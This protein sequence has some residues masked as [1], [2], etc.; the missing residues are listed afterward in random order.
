MNI[1]DP[2]ESNDLCLIN[3]NLTLLD[4]LPTIARG[5][6][7]VSRN[8]LTTLVNGPKIVYQGFN[9]NHNPLLVSLVGGPVEVGRYYSADDCGLT[10]LDGLPRKIGTHLSLDFNPLTSLQGVNKLKEMNGYICLNNCLISSHILGILLIKGC[11]GIITYDRGDFGKA[12]QIMDRYTTKGRS[13][14][15]QCQM[16]LIEAG[17]SE[18]AQI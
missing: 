11:D 17:L 3:K 7:D 12:V 4:G 14:L 6:C 9:C 16:D 8:R 1:S 13:G 5:L 15:I 10:S 18:F 2:A